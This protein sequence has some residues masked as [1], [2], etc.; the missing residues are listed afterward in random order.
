MAQVEE[1]KAKA[2]LWALD[3]IEKPKEDAMAQTQ[4][5]QTCK[6][7]IQSAEETLLDRGY[8]SPVRD[9]RGIKLCSLH[10]SAPELLIAAKWAYDAIRPFSKDPAEQ[11]GIE[12]LRR[13]IQ[14]AEGR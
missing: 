3:R 4:A 2:L 12:K 1:Q 8:Y 10:A 6:C 11:S 9:S 7:R 13:I 14:Q 5:K